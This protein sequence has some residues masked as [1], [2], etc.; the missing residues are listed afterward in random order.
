MPQPIT[1]VVF[2]RENAYQTMMDETAR[3]P[4]LETGGILVG[5]QVLYKG[6]QVL[7]VLAASGPGKHATR[8]AI[9]FVPDV[10][11]DHR[12]L[13]AWRNQYE[14][15]GVDY[16][17]QW[18]KHP[19]GVPS[20]T[21]GDIRQAHAILRDP[22]YLLPHGGILVPITQLGA[23]NTDLHVYYVTR[24]EEH[25]V[26][27]PYHIHDEDVVLEFLGEYTGQDPKPNAAAQTDDGA[28]PRPPGPAAE[29]REETK[30]GRPLRAG[31]RASGQEP[32]PVNGRMIIAQYRVLEEDP[33][34]D[35]QTSH[36]QPSTGPLPVTMVAQALI[37]R[38]SR[39]ERLGRRYGFTLV[40]PDEVTI[41]Y[42]ELVFD[43]AL[44]LPRPFLGQT[45]I[46]TDSEKG[47]SGMPRSSELIRSVR[48]VFPHNY[49]AA[50][51]TM[52][53]VGDHDYPV[54]LDSLRARS[55]D[56][57]ERQIETLIQWLRSSHPKDLPGLIQ[58]NV[59]FLYRH[60]LHVARK[61]VTS[62]D[63]LLAG[64]EQ[65]S[66]GI[67]ITVKTPKAAD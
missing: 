49:P 33:A 4:G 16:V 38:L 48:V 27:C 15:Y 47:R 35:A 45:T 55:A 8:S 37:R 58:A 32:D 7:V 42:I 25:P 2:A 20:L 56:T 43:E 18:H 30:W 40:R 60:G 31:D 63:L 51:P 14:H 44:P 5:R 6:G 67:P 29:A 46:D 17:G 10:D 59:E 24:E 41:D 52:W 12:A 28:A 1:N 19:Y 61:G 11:A 13:E 53:I 9:S 65:K 36:S 21:S 50:E 57:L 62:L 34:S 66:Q 3:S 26:E 22:D 23:D 39:L 54:S 64:L